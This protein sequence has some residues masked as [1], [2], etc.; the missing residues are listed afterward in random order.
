[1]ILR[2]EVSCGPVEHRKTRYIEGVCFRGQFKSNK[3]IDKIQIAE[4]DQCEYGDELN[5]DKYIHISF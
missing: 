2:H 3:V 5:K 4:K 1:M